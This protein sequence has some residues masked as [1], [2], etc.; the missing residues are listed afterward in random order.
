MDNVFKLFVF[1]YYYNYYITSLFYIAYTTVVRDTD[2]K[3]KKL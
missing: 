3:K 1:Y 2:L